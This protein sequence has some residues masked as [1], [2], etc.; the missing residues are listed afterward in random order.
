MLPD[1]YSYTNYREY[2]RDLS[3]ALKAARQFNLRD[4]AKK[5]AIKAPGYLKM[6]IDGRRNLTVQTIHKFCRALDIT[7]RQREY[8]E[9][10]VIYNQTDD[11]D[12]KREYFDKLNRLRPRSQDYVM[13]K[14]QNRY[15]SRPHYVTIREMVLLKDFREDPKWMARRCFPVISPAE[16]K[17]AIDTLLELGL[18]KRDAAGKLLQAEDFVRTDDINTQAIEAYHYHEAMLD[19]ARHA[20]AKLPQKERNY[21]ALT[22]PMPKALFDEIITDFYE[23]RDRIRV[24]VEQAHG[25][26]DDVYQINFQFFPATKKEESKS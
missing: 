2:L 25:N 1:I 18:L 10:L 9:S 16:A 22:I 23:F 13:E 11:P 24:K 21:Y 8:F 15:F 20:L 19:R 4:F 3:A 12:L 17:E 26:L 14:R 6:V 5:A 7:G